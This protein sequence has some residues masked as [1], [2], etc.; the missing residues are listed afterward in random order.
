MRSAAVGAVG[1]IGLLGGI[2]AW[3]AM[4]LGGRL[5]FTVEETHSEGLREVEGSLGV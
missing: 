2:G 3:G 5:R 1:A 4:F